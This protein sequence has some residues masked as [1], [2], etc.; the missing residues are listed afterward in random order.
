MADY[1]LELNESQRLPVLHGEGPM[2]VLAGAGSG[3]TRVLTYRI[4]HLINQGIKPYHILALTFTNKAAK[5]MRARIEALVGP[6]ANQIWMGTFHS[7]FA[8]ILRIEAAYIGYTSQ[9]S[10]Y[11]T[12]DS[13]SLLKTIVKELNLNK[14]TYKPANLGSKI[15][16]LKNKFVTAAAYLNDT[17]AQ[18]EDRR[19][20]TPRFAE[21][22]AR[23]TQRCFMSGAMDFD[24]LLLKVNELFDKSSE[25]LAKYQ[26]KFKYVMVDEYQDTNR[27]Q[28]LIIQ[29]L[30]AFHKN[31][32]VVG[33]DAQSIYAFRGANIQNIINFEKDYPGFSLY[34]LEQNYR[35]TKVI[36]N[37]SSGIIKNN[38]VRLVKEVWTHNEDGDK[39]KVLRASTDAEEGRLVASSIFETKMNQKA[40]NADFAILYRTNSQ[41]RSFEE[42]LRKLNIHYR[43]VG[44]L[45]FYQRKEIKDILAYC[46]L[47]LNPRDEE[48][49]KRVI[50]YPTRGIGDTTLEKVAE[51]AL[52]QDCTLWEALQM[53]IPPGFAPAVASKLR[54]FVGLILQHAQLVAYK[55]AYEVA[56]EITKASGIMAKL[57]EDK[58]IEGISRYDNMQE[59]LAGI[60]GFVEDGQQPD[61]SLAAYMQEVALL[62]DLDQ[63]DDNADHVTLMTVHAAKGLEFPY[64]YIV[65]LEENLFP[66]SRSLGSREE[67]EEERRLFY[68]ALTRAQRRVVISHAMQR[69]KYGSVEFAE[70]S[71]FVAELDT[72][73][74]DQQSAHYD[75]F[76]RNRPGFVLPKPARMV[77]APGLQRVV[78]APSATSKTASQESAHIKIGQKVLHERFGKGLVNAIDG[79]PGNEKA[80]ITFDMYGQKTILLRFAKL[81]VL[82]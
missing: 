72:E 64:V 35:S 17:T 59:L 38:T 32:C 45:S 6:E 55:D 12:D 1:L 71:R 68:V 60:K 7:I 29:K 25:T 76:E 5:E 26:N 48:A 73:L 74:L 31:I 27:V 42:S 44:G 81:S 43:I 28:Y 20:G 18:E 47:V 15:S 33:D 56:L 10:I 51:M 52:A 75:D 4:A 69:F 78:S 50:N 30:A 16:G 57:Y 11:D 39:I 37:A 77:P 80:T 8:K 21:I 22:Y 14:E 3:K 9:F 70:P 82:Q 66:S 36:V 46:R 53:A 58:S 65:G 13:R 49:L 62:S 61:K 41:S 63:K 34:K 19:S 54:W 79:Q 23:Y 24:D 2:M 40:G 67:L